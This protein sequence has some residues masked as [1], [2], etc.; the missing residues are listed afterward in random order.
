MRVSLDT[1]ADADRRWCCEDA[2]AP[3]LRLAQ[4]YRDTRAISTV[5]MARSVQP[6]ARE[7][8]VAGEL[9]GIIVIPPD[10][11]GGASTRAGM[12][13][14][15]IITDGSQPNTANFV[16][17]YAEG[18]RAQ[19]GGGAKRLERDRAAPAR[20]ST[21]SARFWFNP[22]LTEPLSSSCRARSPS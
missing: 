14:I 16:A 4:A 17:A 15:Q 9:R 8:L 5:T 12:P 2:S 3:A 20:R 13:T 7:D 19:L 21:S 22:E 6:S 18:V 10:F 11:G 1:H